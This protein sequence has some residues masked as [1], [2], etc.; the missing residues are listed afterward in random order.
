[1]GDTLLNSKAYNTAETLLTSRVRLAHPAETQVNHSNYCGSAGAGERSAVEAVP[2]PTRAPDRVRKTSVAPKKVM[3]AFNTWAFKREQPDD[4]ALMTEIIAD[5][6]AGGLPVPFVL[7]WGKG[8][9]CKLDDPDI[10]CLD[11]LAALGRRVREVYDAGTAIKLIFTDTHARLNGHTSEHIRDYFNAVDA[12]ARARGFA[13]CWLGDLVCL[14][15]AAGVTGQ[16]D[17][18]VPADTLQRLGAC[19]A[20]WYRGAGTPEHGALQYYKMNMIEKCAVQ[21]ACPRSIFV[22]FNGSEFRC[23][24]PERLPIFYMYSLRRG[25][26]VK[27]W[28]LPPVMPAAPAAITDPVTA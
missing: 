15:E 27:P 16:F 26:S 12:S 8:P 10:V 11:Y 6:I 21:L 1:M 9:R 3:Q 24:F 17:D 19:A 20:K 13:S 5:S 23:L 22:T 25:V 18:D 28:F 7:Y 2:V 14:A 4:P